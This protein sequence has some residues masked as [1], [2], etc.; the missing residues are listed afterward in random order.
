MESNKSDKFEVLRRLVVAG[1]KREDL[2]STVRVALSL[3]CDIVELAGAAF[4]LWNDDREIDLA[5]THASSD[6]NLQRLKQ[7]EDDLYADLRRERQLVS[8]YMSFGGDSPF[9]SFTLPLRLGKSI[10]GAV[11]GIQEGDR[12]PL[13]EDLFLEALSAAISLNVLAETGG[14]EAGLSKEAI[15]RERLAAILE[16]AVTV[17]HEINNPLT[18]ILGN[19]QLLLLKSEE[20]DNELEAKLKTIE[21]SAMKIRDVTQKL[22][23]LTTPKSTSY[24]DGTKMIDL[25]EDSES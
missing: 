12:S 21:Q 16:T 9:H 25:S 10:L 14:G 15:N 5:V 18:A 1:S 11:I 22:M 13:Q 17:N 20:L 3:A 2:Q 24:N 7:L 23:R 19:V 8:A 6:N 4:Y